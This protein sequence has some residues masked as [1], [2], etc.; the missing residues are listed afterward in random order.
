MTTYCSMFHCS[1]VTV[2]AT[3]TLLHLT[4]CAEPVE[5][6]QALGPSPATTAEPARFAG[7]SQE[8][9]VRAIFTA[10]GWET[11]EMPFQVELDLFDD[12]SGCPQKTPAADTTTVTTDCTR[13]DGTQLSGMIVYKNWTEDDPTGPVEARYTDFRMVS[14][15]DDILALNGT[16]TF[17]TEDTMIAS[18]TELSE[19]L[20]TT[21][22]ATWRL[23]T[24]GKLTADAGSTV[25]L[26]GLGIAE[27]AGSWS[28]DLDLPAG[29]LSLQGADLLV[30]D[31]D[32]PVNGCAPMTVDGNPAGEVCTNEE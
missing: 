24:D 22:E 4:A 17:P 5:L 31:F 8:Q 10:G 1:L 19:G 15:A 7:A 2:T 25:E 23:G 12:G 26:T 13:A 9:K 28:L 29:T 6:P 16:V 30:V 18:L 3:A 27:I 21:T 11:S 14:G 32:H 20:E